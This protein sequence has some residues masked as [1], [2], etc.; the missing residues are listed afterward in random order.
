MSA[1]FSYSTT[2]ILNKPHFNECFS[3]SVT[4]DRSWRKYTK[5]AILISLGAYWLFFTAVSTYLAWFMVG[6]GVLDII[7]L[8]YQQ[9]WW[10]ARQML[11]RAANSEITLIIDDVGITTKSAY[12]NAVI[13]W[14]DINKLIATDCGFLIEHKNG[15]SYLSNQCLDQSAITYLLSKEMA[16]NQS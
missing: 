8:R 5:A 14:Q 12:N 1:A 9:P 11:S 7:A 16:T 4:V 10:V 6:L 3:Q 13:L 15:R 2:F